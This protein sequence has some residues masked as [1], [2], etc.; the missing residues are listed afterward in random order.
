MENNITELE[1]QPEVDE[2]GAKEAEAEDD[3]GGR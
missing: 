1:Y 2:Y 3:G